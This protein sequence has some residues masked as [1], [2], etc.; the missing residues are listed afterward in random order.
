MTQNWTPN[1]SQFRIKLDLDFLI[2]TLNNLLG[3]KIKN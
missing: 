3:T 1:E 2:F